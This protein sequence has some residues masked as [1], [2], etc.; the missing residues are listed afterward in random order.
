[1]RLETDEK[2]KFRQAP[3][4]HTPQARH[5][6]LARASR[7]S[8]SGARATNQAV[9]RGGCE[10]SASRWALVGVLGGGPSGIAVSLAACDVSALRRATATGCRDLLASVKSRIF[11]LW[12][13]RLLLCPSSARGSCTPSQPWATAWCRMVLHRLH[14]RHLSCMHSTCTAQCTEYI[15]VPLCVCMALKFLRF[16]H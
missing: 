1:V 6:A 5:V 12:I 13:C 3:P 16:G 14:N 9:S 10:L 11:L 2:K 8:P 7:V 4:T 15:H